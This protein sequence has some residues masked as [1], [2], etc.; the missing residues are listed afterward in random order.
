MVTGAATEVQRNSGQPPYIRTRA[1]DKALEAAI[2]EYKAALVPETT[3]L[4]LRA[5]GP[6]SAVAV[7]HAR[8]PSRGRRSG[9]HGLI[10][11]GTSEWRAVR[12]PLASL[13]RE[14]TRLAAGPP[15]LVG[16]LVSP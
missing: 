4:P 5:P 15:S 2:D 13:L 14:T 9:A 7:S 11:T 16:C 6:R 10:V 12:E 3:A 8:R 1:D